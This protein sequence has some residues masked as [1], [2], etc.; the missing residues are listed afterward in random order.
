MIIYA[1]NNEFDI[2]YYVIAKPPEQNSISMNIN[3]T[4]LT[5]TE[6][7]VSVFALENGLPFPRVITS[8]KIVILAARSHQGLYIYMHVTWHTLIQK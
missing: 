1:I 7:G 5:G 6:Y 3:L 4:V 8:P 2:H